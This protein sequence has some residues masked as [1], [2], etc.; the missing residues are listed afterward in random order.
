[1]AIIDTGV[2]Y[3]HPALG[4]GFGDGKRVSGGMLLISLYLNMSF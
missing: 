1:V 3:L 4:N 2:Y